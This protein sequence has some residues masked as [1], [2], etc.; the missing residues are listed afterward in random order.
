MSKLTEYQL[1][2][3]DCSKCEVE[4]NDKP[5]GRKVLCTSC[6]KEASSEKSK[7][8]KLKKRGKKCRH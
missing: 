2:G 1:E 3:M 6:K 5:V 7:D 4:V 8:V